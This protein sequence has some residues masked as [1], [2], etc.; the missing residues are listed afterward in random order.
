[1]LVY[2]ASKA[3][4]W[5]WWQALR[6]AGLPIT[7]SWIDW[8]RNIDNTEPDDDEWRAHSAKSL[9][10]AAAADIVLLYVDREDVRHF[11][12][13]LEAGAALGAG[14]WVYLVAPHE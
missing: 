10:Q 8:E 2:V 12:S 5:P 14:K 1:V 9:E 6:S 3:K 13:L 7:S 4:F 11:G